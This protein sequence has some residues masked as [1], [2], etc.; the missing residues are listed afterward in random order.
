MYA[1]ENIIRNASANKGDKLNILVFNEFNDSYICEMADN[2]DH[3]FFIVK[4][5]C[6]HNQWNSVEKPSN[7]SIINNYAEYHNRNIDVAISFNRGNT[8]SR[9]YSI[10]NMLHI[11]LVVIDFTSS[12]IRFPHP[13]GSNINKDAVDAAKLSGEFSVGISEFVTKSWYSS[14]PSIGMNISYAGKKYDMNG[15][16]K[17]LIDSNLDRTYLQQTGIRFEN[18]PYTFDIKEASAYLHLWKNQNSLIFDCMLNRIPV[19]VSRSDDLSELFGNNLCLVLDDPQYF[20]N[21][22]NYESFFSNESVKMT[23]ENAYQYITSIDRTKFMEE[24]NNI[25]SHVSNKCFVRN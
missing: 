2:S 21:R 22:T 17:I 18:H 9:A 5:F 12:Q 1:I 16:G 7:L 25:L 8:T 15:A 3:E 10:T 11:P 23:V 13:I 14:V 20:N 6:E 4:S 24:W 19:L